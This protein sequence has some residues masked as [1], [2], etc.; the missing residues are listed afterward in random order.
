LGELM[1]QYKLP[2]AGG[3]G[4]E[5]ALLKLATDKKKMIPTTAMNDTLLNTAYLTAI[6]ADLTEEHKPAKDVKDWVAYSHDMRKGAVELAETVKAKDGKAAF[7]A[8]GKVN[9]SCSACHDK[10]RK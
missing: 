5:A 2:K 9:T 8:L 6:I 10:F 1:S 3:Q 7:V 4:M